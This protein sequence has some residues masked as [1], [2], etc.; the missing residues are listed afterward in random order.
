MDHRKNIDL[1][2]FDMDGTIFTSNVNWRSVK[3]KLNVNNTTILEKLYYGID[4]DKDGLRYLEDIEEKSTKAA[5]PVPG[6]L[7]F[8][9]EIRQRGIK[10][11]LVTNNSRRNAEY[12]LNKFNLSFDMVI[13]RDENMWKPSPAAFRFSMKMFDIIP[14]N[15]ISIGDSD[16][17]IS[18][19]VNSDI[20]NIYI[21]RNSNIS[22]KYLDNFRYFKDFNDLSSKIFIS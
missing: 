14:E 2:I 4:V 17:D 8:I 1:I 5:E 7:E 20:S 21:I 6:S 10:S 3:E 12:L 15:T 9:D 13:T 16:L 19:S 18:A 22:G 11:S